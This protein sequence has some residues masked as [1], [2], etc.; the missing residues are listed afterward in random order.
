MIFRSRVVC[1]KTL[2]S[3][4]LLLHLFSH[5]EALLT[6]TTM[7]V[8]IAGMTLGGFAAWGSAGIGATF[9]GL[10]LGHHREY[11][12]PP[13][14]SIRLLGTAGPMVLVDLDVNTGDVR[15]IQARDAPVHDEFKFTM[16][17]GLRPNMVLAL[18]KPDNPEDPVYQQS[19][20]NSQVV[21]TTWNQET[22]EAEI[23][24]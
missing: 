9:L 23:C 5:L 8:V 3:S 20:A 15:E 22:G 16:F 10:F 2:P 13:T 14:I 7:G 4:H 19:L 17:S 21:L 1:N 11:F 12:M 6:T 18:D 24:W